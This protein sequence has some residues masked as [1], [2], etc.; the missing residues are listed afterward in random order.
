MSVITAQKTQ[1]QGSFVAKCTNQSRLPAGTGLGSVSGN[2]GSLKQSQR[3]LQPPTR[4]ALSLWCQQEF[5]K[6]HPNSHTQGSISENLSGSSK[7]SARH[8]RTSC[9][10]TVPFKMNYTP[11]VLDWTVHRFDNLGIH[12]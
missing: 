1:A 9:T 7:S 11:R 10:S 12:D 2:D 8:T 5:C 4:K 3:K 6:T